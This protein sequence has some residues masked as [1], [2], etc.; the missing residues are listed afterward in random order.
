MDRSRPVRLAVVVALVLTGS[1]VVAYA[2]RPARAALAAGPSKFVSVPQVR[3][4]DTDTRGGNLGDGGTLSVPVT[5]TNGVPST[6]VTAVV[7]SLTAIG[8]VGNLVA[9]PSDEAAPGISNL[10]V[11]NGQAVNNMAIV[12]VSSYY[13]GNVPPG[14]LTVRNAAGSTHIFV[15][16]QGYYLA[17]P[18]SAGGSGYMPIQPTRLLDTRYGVG[19]PYGPVPGNQS[20]LV[21]ATGGSTTVPAGAT[22][23]SVNIATINPQTNGYVVA[24]AYQPGGRTDG[25]DKPGTATVN[26]QPGQDVD[27][28]DQV[29]LGAD[30]RFQ[31]YVANSPLNLA[32]DVTGYYVNSGGSSYV[33]LPGT[34]IINTVAGG[35]FYANTAT[36]VSYTNNAGG[37]GIPASDV[38]AVALDITVLNNTSGGN[39]R[40]Y[41]TDAPAVPNIASLNYHTP[42][43]AVTNLVIS[44]LDRNGRANLYSAQFSTSDHVDV[45]IDVVGYYT[46][47]APEPPSNVQATPGDTQATVTWSPG[48]SFGRAITGY[49][50]YT[51]D[52]GT[53]AL[54]T[55]TNVP[56]GACPSTCSATAPGLQGGRTVVFTVTETN[57]APAT[58]GESGPSNSV[59]P[60]GPPSSPTAA[61]LTAGDRQL[62]ASW[63]VPAYSNPA[64]SSYN[65]YVTDATTG[66]Q[67]GGTYF[68]VT[69]TNKTL[70]GND[71]VVPG[72][73]YRANIVACNSRG[74][75]PGAG[76]PTAAV[77]LPPPTSLSP[78]GASSPAA[79]TVSS[80]T[81]TL[82]SVLAAAG[83]DSL[84]ARVTVK[85]P[86]G[87]TVAAGPGEFKRW[88]RHAASDSIRSSSSAGVFHLC[89]WRGRPLSCT[90][91]A[92]R[93]AWV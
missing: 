36:P 38:S 44:R 52:A 25:G 31:V 37:D 12:R 86:L 4:Y 92:S 2:G 59:N 90:A 17:G 55:S 7:V 76:T 72:H 69:G 15:D 57:S 56:V 10:Q 30:G 45:I 74:C 47:S 39:L 9:Y 26:L 18:G 83:N 65:V 60:T 75:G 93:V 22:A 82:N 80:G 14:S 42:P 63:S 68:T 35:P 61:S 62:Q 71:G 13:S 85:D 19:G 43:A 84:V 77:A 64:V 70:T 6:G 41:P 32:V 23:V 33:P 73:A 79:T 20:V 34:R 27:N 87:A 8:Q 88:V 28:A 48:T 50:V 54:L 3:L 78:G 89:R 66:Q 11:I 53:R 49:T 81:P 67:L 5:G 1:L 91:T 58:S 29:P 46:A 24:Y 40:V 21:Q 16:L 51:R